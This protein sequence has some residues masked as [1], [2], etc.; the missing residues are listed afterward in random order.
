MDPQYRSESSA[1]LRTFKSTRNEDWT[2]ITSMEGS[3]YSSAAWMVSFAI[4]E[5]C[6]TL[7]G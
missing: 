6:G 2:S 7:Q 5:G 3:R 1:Q 4:L